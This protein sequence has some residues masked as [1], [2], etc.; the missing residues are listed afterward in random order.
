[1]KAEDLKKGSIVEIKINLS[2]DK[3]FEPVQVEIYRCS[4][5]YIWFKYNSLRR[6]GRSTF[7]TCI[8]HFGYKIISI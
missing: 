6:M 2:M 1:M 7:N 4:E 5:K 3:M 8:K